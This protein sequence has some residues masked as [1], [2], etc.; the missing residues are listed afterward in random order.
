MVWATFLGKKKARSPKI[1]W[2]ILKRE[3]IKRKES[4]TVKWI[5]TLSRC[6]CS[7]NFRFDR[8][9]KFKFILHYI[10]RMLAKQ[11][12]NL[13]SLVSLCTYAAH[14]SCLD[15]FTSLQSL[16]VGR[17][18]FIMSI[19]HHKLNY[20]KLNTLQGYQRAKLQFSLDSWVGI[21]FLPILD[22]TT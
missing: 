21:R 17:F 19:N 14:H 20:S 4:N 16:K 18:H 11:N 5:L 1:I 6:S 13:D 9:M 12:G 8:I 3:L 15:S 10:S 7:A 2:H 22:Q